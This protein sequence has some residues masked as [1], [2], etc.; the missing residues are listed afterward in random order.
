MEEYSPPL[1][2]PQKRDSRALVFKSNAGD[3]IQISLTSLD[4]HRPEH[5]DPVIQVKIEVGLI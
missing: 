1:Q 5:D 4:Y 3:V 2:K